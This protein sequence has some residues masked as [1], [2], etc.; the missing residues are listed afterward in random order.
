MIVINLIEPL[1]VERCRQSRPVA[2]VGRGLRSDRS[3]RAGRRALGQYVRLNPKDAQAVGELARQYSKAGNWQ[4]TLE[5]AIAAESL[6]A[7]DLPL[8]LLRI[9]AGIHVAARQ[10]GDE[11]TERLQKLSAELA[12]LRRA[13]PDQVDIRLLQVGVAEALG[14]PQQAEDEL[15]LAIAECKEPLKARMQLA[16]FYLRAKRTKEA[17]DVCRAA[18]QVSWCDRRAMACPGGCPCGSRRLRFRLP[19]SQRRV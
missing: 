13:Q 7:A 14:Q 5:T 12:E 2:A 16:D 4:K 19:R 1:V 9:E 6:G 11:R 17:A 3:G 10:R 18:C 15:K 8:T